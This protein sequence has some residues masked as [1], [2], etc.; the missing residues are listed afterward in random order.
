MDRTEAR[1]PESLGA[2]FEALLAN[3]GHEVPGRYGFE[4]ARAGLYAVLLERR[5]TRIH[6]PRYICSAVLSA[7]AAAGTRPVFYSVQPDFRFELDEFSPADDL[8]MV[9]NYFGL[10]AGPV[11]HALAKFPRDALIV[12][13]AQAYFQAPSEVLAN[14]YSPRKFLPV[15]DG[16]F[17]AGS[18]RL[19]EPE[20]ADEDATFRRFRYL[21]ERIGERPEISRPAYLE[22]EA[23]LEPPTLRGMSNLSRRLTQGLDQGFVRRKRRENYAALTALAAI[24]SLSIDIGD[25]VPLC[26]PLMVE[27]GANLRQSLLDR[28]IFCPRYWPDAEP[29]N[30]FEH[31]LKNS[32]IYLPIDH[33]YD[34]TDMQYMVETVTN[35]RASHEYHQ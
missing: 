19:P 23:S 5:P 7:V 2:H 3:W 11:A 14:I 12:D 24:N 4:S 35:W 25:Q 16:G 26:Y 9:V 21:L 31:A 6:L 22:A 28:R 18:I 8:V 29:T 13:N 17:V 1:I 15:P 32:T 20:P 33:R 30:A 34:L 10:C 27:D